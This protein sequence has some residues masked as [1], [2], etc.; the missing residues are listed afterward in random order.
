MIA[1][2]RR[3]ASIVYKVV[4]DLKIHGVSRPIQLN[5]RMLAKKPGAT[6]TDMRTGF[7]CSVELKRSDFKM[8]NLLEDAK[9]GDAIAITVSF[10]GVQQAQPA[11]A[12]PNS[13]IIFEVAE[14]S[15]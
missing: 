2:K 9:V 12:P 6:G 11:A 13:L 15:F 3:T 5:V 14:L 1:L 4:G 7:L 10:E 8:T